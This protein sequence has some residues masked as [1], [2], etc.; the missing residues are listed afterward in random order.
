MFQLVLKMI[1]DNEH[2]HNQ[3]KK[4]TFNADRD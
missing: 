3:N 2:T 4:K 1:E